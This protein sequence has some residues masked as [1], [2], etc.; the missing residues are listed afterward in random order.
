MADHLVDAGAD[1]LGKVLVV[2]R[3]RICPAG[4]AQVVHVDVDLVG[5]NAGLHEFARESQHFGGG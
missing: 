4:D 3:A 2:E 1:A 5:G